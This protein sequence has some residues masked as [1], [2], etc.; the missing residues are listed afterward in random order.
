ML[1]SSFA[2][3]AR[4]PMLK[5]AQLLRPIAQQL[6]NNQLFAASALDYLTNCRLGVFS[7]RAENS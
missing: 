7:F 6:K 5:L 2:Q 4:A 1:A 3:V